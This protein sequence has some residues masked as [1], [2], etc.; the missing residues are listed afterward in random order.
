M[1]PKVGAIYEHYKGG[2]YRVLA[3]GEHTETGERLVVYSPLGTGKNWIR[4]LDMWNEAV[5]GRHRFVEVEDALGAL[6]AYF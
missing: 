2:R 4:P 1:E 6:R 5:G 3:I